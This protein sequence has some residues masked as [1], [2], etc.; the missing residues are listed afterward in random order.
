MHRAHSPAPHSSH[1]LG[2]YTIRENK[3]HLYHLNDEQKKEIWCSRQLVLYLYPSN[4]AIIKCTWN[5]AM[6]VR[7]CCTM[8]H[9]H[10]AIC[11]I[12]VYADGV[13]CSAVNFFLIILSKY[14]PEDYMRKPKITT[15]ISRK[16][17]TYNLSL[18]HWRLPSRWPHLRCTFYQHSQVFWS[19]HFSCASIS[20]H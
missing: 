3:I 20:C 13:V 2:L 12:T 10:F 17:S 7:M 14:K 11:F 19:L 5:C 18:K 4:S 1:S 6:I 8:L 16:P 9:T 15:N